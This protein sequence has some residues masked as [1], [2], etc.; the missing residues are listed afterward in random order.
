[1]TNPSVITF[2]FLLG[3]LRSSIS[4][5]LVFFFLE[6]TFWVLAAGHFTENLT[7]T[8]AGGGLGVVSGALLTI[9][10]MTLTLFRSPPSLRST[11]PSLV[12]LPRRPRTSS[13]RSATF[14]AKP[15][16]PSMFTHL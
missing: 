4:L 7:V 14:L 12:S 8:K 10:Y 11:L 16:S 13:S 2:I 1:M 9:D 6:I 3:T 15:I 5:F